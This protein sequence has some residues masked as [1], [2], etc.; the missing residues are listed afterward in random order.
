MSYKKRRDTVYSTKLAEIFSVY[1]LQYYASLAAG[2]QQMHSHNK[3]V[4]PP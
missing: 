3:N 2:D 1:A 4:L